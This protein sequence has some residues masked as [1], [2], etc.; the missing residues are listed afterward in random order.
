[1]AARWDGM[2]WFSEEEYMAIASNSKPIVRILDALGLEN[3]RSMT[4]SAAVGSVVAVVTEQYVTG[5]QLERLAGELETKE[6]V[7]VPKA[8]WI[9]MQ[10]SAGRIEPPKPISLDEV[11]QALE[12]PGRPVP[13]ANLRIKSGVIPTAEEVLNRR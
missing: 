1:M 4:I 5:D 9:D 2:I 8:E 10:V 7:L 6:W 12:L 11:K 3:V 13:P